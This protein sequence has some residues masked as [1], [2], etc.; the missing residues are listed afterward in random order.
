MQLYAYVSCSLKWYTYLWPINIFQY[1]FGSLLVERV[2]IF[3]EIG[4]K[5]EW[6]YFLEGNLAQRNFRDCTVFNMTKAQVTAEELLCWLMT[7]LCIIIE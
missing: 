1:S 2:E 7:T 6:K 3:L 4:V 5:L